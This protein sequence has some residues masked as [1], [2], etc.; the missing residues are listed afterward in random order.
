MGGKQLFAQVTHQWNEK[1]RPFA[2]IAGIH[3]ISR[4]LVLVHRQ[5]VGNITSALLFISNI[6][7]HGLQRWEQFKLQQMQNHQ[8]SQSARQLREIQDM[9][10]QRL[11]QQQTEQQQALNNVQNDETGPAAPEQKE[12][13][14]ATEEEKHDKTIEK[15]VENRIRL[16]NERLNKY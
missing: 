9:E 10:Y 15:I 3:P 14:E 1:R 12:E 7:D 11:V 4:K 5:Y 13:K 16:A 8:Q 2:V 6:L